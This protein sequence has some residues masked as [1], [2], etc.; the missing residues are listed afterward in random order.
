MPVPLY[1]V[2]SFINASL[3][4]VIVINIINKNNSCTSTKKR[5]RMVD[6]QLWIEA[7][8]SVQHQKKKQD[9]L[10]HESWKKHG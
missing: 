4:S 3:I 7:L 8:C 1:I 2:W 6:W 10:Q 9:C 5:E